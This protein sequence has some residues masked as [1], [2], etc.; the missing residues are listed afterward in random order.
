MTKNT[1]LLNHALVEWFEFT[2][3]DVIVDTLEKED[4]YIVHSKMVGAGFKIRHR[5]NRCLE[6]ERGL[7]SIHFLDFPDYAKII[8]ENKDIFRSLLGDPQKWVKALQGELVLIRNAMRHSRGG[9]LSDRR[10][11]QLIGWCE[12]LQ[13]VNEARKRRERK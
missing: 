4:Q 2:L 7:S 10:A 6:E 3:R 9:Y 5:Y 11:L 13:E 1:I 12:K 8:D